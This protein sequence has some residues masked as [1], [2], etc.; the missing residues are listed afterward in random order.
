MLF[1]FGLVRFINSFI[2]GNKNIIDLI[3]LILLEALAHIFG[4]VRSDLD[5]VNGTLDFSFVHIME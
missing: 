2:G 1:S 3:D 4:N 5:T